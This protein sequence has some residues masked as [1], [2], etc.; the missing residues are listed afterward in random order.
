MLAGFMVF[1][2]QEGQVGKGLDAVFNAGRCY[3]I[4]TLDFRKDR[5]EI[6]LILCSVLAGFMVFTP[7]TSCCQKQF[8]FYSLCV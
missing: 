2:L 4:H 6:A 3:G 8:R 7:E 1:T 5:G